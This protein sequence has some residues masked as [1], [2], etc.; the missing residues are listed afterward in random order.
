MLLLGL[1][2]AG[3]PTEGGTPQPS[4]GQH[5]GREVLGAIARH[6]LWGRGLGHSV[7]AIG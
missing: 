3:D 4:E 6:D 1:L 5:G 2:G 7:G